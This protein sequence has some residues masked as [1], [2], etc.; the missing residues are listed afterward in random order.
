MLEEEPVADSVM[1]MGELV[2]RLVGVPLPFGYVHF[3]GADGETVVTVVS[4]TAGFFDAGRLPVGTYTIVV[5]VKGLSLYRADLVLGGNADLRLSVITDSFQL[6]TL[7]EVAIVAPK[8]LLTGSGQLITSADDPRLWDFTYCDWCPWSGPPRIAAASSSGDPNNPEGRVKWG[9]FYRPAKGR[10]NI[11]IW[12]IL[13][14]D[15]V[16]SAP[17]EKAVGNKEEESNDE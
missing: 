17:K 13:W 11:R 1:V 16:T 7:R 5:Q 4:D 2:D 8:H 6:R 12:Q 10:K 3:L 14:P 15:R 9:R